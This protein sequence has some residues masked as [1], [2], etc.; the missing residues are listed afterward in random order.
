MV[1]PWF[2]RVCLFSPFFGSTISQALPFYRSG[3]VPAWAATSDASSAVAVDHR[4]LAAA[5]RIRDFDEALISRM[6]GGLAEREVMHG[7][8]D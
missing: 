5:Q 4:R 8:S 1:L 3:P 7:G 6:F 2:S